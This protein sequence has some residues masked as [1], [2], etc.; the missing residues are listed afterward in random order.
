MTA[1]TINDE[2]LKKGLLDDTLT[3]VNLEGLYIFI[4][5]DLLEM[6]SKLVVLI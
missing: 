2:K 3:V 5:A 4:Y 6:K 1:T